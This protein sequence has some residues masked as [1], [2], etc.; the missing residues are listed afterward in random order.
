MYERLLLCPFAVAELTLPNPNVYYELGVRHATRPFSTIGLFAEGTI[1]PFD[2]TMIRALPYQVGPDG[3]VA[4]IQKAREA[5]AKRLEAARKTAQ[6]G[7]D[8]SPLFQLMD[9]PWKSQ[10]RFLDHQKTDI[11]RE[12]TRY[13]EERKQQ[14]KSARAQGTTAVQAIEADIKS[15]PG[16]LQNTELGVVIDLFLS[17][18]AVEAWREM[19]RLVGEMSQ[20]VAQTVMVREQHAFALNR[21]A[22]E[23]VKQGNAAGARM[24]R[25]QAIAILEALIK[26]R[27][28]SSETN[29]IL[30]RVYKDYWDEAKAAKND[31]L[32]RGQLTK[33][34]DAYVR[35]F[36]A[37]WR[38]AYPG[39]NAVTLMEVAEPP[40]KRRKTLIPVVRYSVERKLAAKNPDYWDFA[41]RLELA[42]L[43]DDPKSAEKALDDALANQREKWEPK[44]T[45]RNLGLIREARS[46]RGED[47]VWLE[48]VERKLLA[49]AT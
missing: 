46:K 30:G 27:G 36:E 3:M 39:I 17:Y 40:D 16:G 29:G 23:L 9:I 12:Q 37:D 8:D 34:I 26:E 35:G 21:V 25:E 33:A 1:L 11:F 49:A 20:P 18:R 48:E 19:I 14:L 5:I 41:T 10:L 44:T 47:V 38:D 24:L 32:A 42:V 28:D 15:S 31:S 22:G 2:L 45:A 6:A 7:S 4:D 43:A 13:S